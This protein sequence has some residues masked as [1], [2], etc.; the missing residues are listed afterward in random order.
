M[1]VATLDLTPELFLEFAKACTGQGL[2]RRFLVKEHPLPDDAKIVDIRLRYPR[3]HTLQLLVQSES[4]A[5]VPEGEKPPELP[6]VVFETVFD[7]DNDTRPDGYCKGG[8]G[9]NFYEFPDM[10]H[11]Q[12]D[13]PGPECTCYEIIGGHQMGCYFYGRAAN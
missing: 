7:S 10:R 3:R 6:L 13:C 4:F 9:L 11:P 1:R 2:T 8:C 5:E 12:D